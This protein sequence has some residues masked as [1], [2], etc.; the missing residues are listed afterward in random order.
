MPI[1]GEIFSIEMER[2]WLSVRNLIESLN[3]VDILEGQD[4][5]KKKKG[6]G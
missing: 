4:D 2:L 6:R 3:P 1:R 5:E